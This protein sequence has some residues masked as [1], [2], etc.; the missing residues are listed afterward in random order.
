[1]STR[2]G[3]GRYSS[4][5][6]VRKLSVFDRCVPEGDYSSFEGCCSPRTCT[7]VRSSQH[8]LRVLEAKGDGSTAQQPL[9]MECALD[10][11]QLPPHNYSVASGDESKHATYRVD[12]RYGDVGSKTAVL[13]SLKAHYFTGKRKAYSISNALL[14]ATNASDHISDGISTSSR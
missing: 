2:R 5:P 1:M 3:E 11:F 9:G 4:L 12:L 14:A 10:G 7:H 8:V 6:Y 13:R